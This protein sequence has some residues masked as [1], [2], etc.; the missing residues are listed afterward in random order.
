[1]LSWITQWAVPSDA[2]NYDAQLRFLCFLI[3]PIWLP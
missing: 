2:P 3:D 1:M